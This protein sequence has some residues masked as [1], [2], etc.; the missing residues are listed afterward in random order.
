MLLNVLA[1]AADVIGDIITDPIGFLGKL[2]DGVKAGLT[3]FVGNIATH[4]KKGLMG[5]LFGALGE[6]GIEMPKTFDL[7]G[8]FELVMDVLGLTYRSIRARVAKLVGEPVVAKMEQT[9]DVFKTLVTEGHRRPL[10]VDQGQ[11]RRP[12]GH[13]ARRHQGLHHR[14]VIKGGITWLLSLLNPA[15]AFIK[16]CKAIYD[17][18]MF[19]VERGSADHGVRQLD[20]RLDRRDRPRPASA[21][22][23]TRS[24][25]RSPRRSRWRSPSSPACS[26]SAGSARRS[27]E[28]I[29]K[30]R[31]PIDEGRR[32]RRHGRREGLQEAVRRRDRLGQG[33]VREGQGVG[34]GQGRRR[35]RNGAAGKVQGIKDR[36]TGKPDEAEPAAAHEDAAKPVEVPFTMHGKPRTLVVKGGRVEMHS[37]PAELVGR[38]TKMYDELTT[39]KPAL[40]TRAPPRCGRR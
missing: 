9:V 34:Q 15:A 40:A 5:W 28:V 27:S 17:I 26:A 21:S 24:R 33:Q 6:A 3:R 31:K 38:V 35:R 18:V 39:T 16:A 20:P 7:A 2:V 32:L 13:G 30:V 12:R 29:E 4:L 25:A 10:G 1:K 19:I 14:E 23:P 36:I 22:S 8:I 11:G 37:T